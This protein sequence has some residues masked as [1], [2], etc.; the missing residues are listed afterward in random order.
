MYI[1]LIENQVL[2]W[3]RPIKEM[4]RGRLV[5]E[6]KQDKEQERGEE[7]GKTY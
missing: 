1:F 6:I 5:G 7:P 2:F 4:A 3:G